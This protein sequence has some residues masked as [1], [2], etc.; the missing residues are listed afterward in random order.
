M[1]MK[2]GCSTPNDKKSAVMNGG[3]NGG[4]AKNVIV[5]PASDTKP[6]GYDGNNGY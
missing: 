5:V 1:C 2:C 4:S 3:N 6:G